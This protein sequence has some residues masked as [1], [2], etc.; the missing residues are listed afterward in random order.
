MAERQVSKDSQAHTLRSWMLG[1]YTTCGG[2]TTRKELG[3]C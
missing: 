2:C 1:F 3:N